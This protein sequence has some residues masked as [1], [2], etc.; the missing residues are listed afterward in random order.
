MSCKQRDVHCPDMRGP[1]GEYIRATALACKIC[2]SESEILPLL[3]STYQQA[4]GR[5]V[6]ERQSWGSFP[7]WGQGLAHVPKGACECH[8]RDLLWTLPQQGWARGVF[9]GMLHPSAGT[10]TAQAALCFVPLWDFQV[11]L[12]WERCATTPTEPERSS[13][14]LMGSTGV[15]QPLPHQPR[16]SPHVSPQTNAGLWQN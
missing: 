7:R 5:A 12:P 1:L 9:L 13:P 4:V 14:S 2:G 6:G 3:A 11:P 10:C 15:S 16:K 8:G